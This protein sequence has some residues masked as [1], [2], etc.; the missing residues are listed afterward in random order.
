MDHT[1]IFTF[2]SDPYNNFIKTIIDTILI[3]IYIGNNLKAL[4]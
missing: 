4:T 1:F 3:F 2:I